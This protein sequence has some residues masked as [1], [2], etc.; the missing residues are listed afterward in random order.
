MAYEIIPRP[1]RFL[2]QEDAFAYEGKI[3][4]PDTAKRRPSTGTIV[5]I[6][7]NTETDLVVGDRIIYPIYSGT[8][9]RLRDTLNPGKDQTPMRILTSDEILSKIKGDVELIEAGS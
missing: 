7:I 4:I 1:G 6:G 9:L 3:L 2:I 5:A 8:G